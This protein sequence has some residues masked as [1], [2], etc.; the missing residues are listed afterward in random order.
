MKDGRAVEE[1][2]VFGSRH[3]L[4][5]FKPYLENLWVLSDPELCGLLVLKCKNIKFFI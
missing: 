2:I 5:N 3:S 1:T 4:A